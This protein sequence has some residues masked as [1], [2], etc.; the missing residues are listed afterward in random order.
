M[1]PRAAKHLLIG[2]T[3]AYS[4]KSATILGLAQPLLKQGVNLAY[5]KPLSQIVP[6]PSDGVDPD[7]Q[8]MAQTLGLSPK[9]LHP[10]LLWLNSERIHD[11][12]QGTD[13]TLYGQQLAHSCEQFAGDLLLLEGP[14]S[15]DEGHLFGLSLQQVADIVDAQVVLV[16][17]YH[18]LSVVDTLLC[19]KQRLGDRLLGVVINDVPAD[20]RQWCEQPL[21]D[22]LEAQG[23]RVLGLL[24]RS[25]LLRSVSVAELVRQ[26]NAEVLCCGDR[27]TLM[28]E[29]LA[30]GAMNVNSALKYFRKAQHMAVITGGDRTDIQ[31]AALESSTHCLILT[32][33]FSPNS[34]VLNRAED[35][36][37][38]VLLVDLD[39]L[40]TVEIVDQAFGQA[41]LHE[42]VKVEHVQQM[43]A[44]YFDLDRLLV[45]L[46]LDIGVAV[47]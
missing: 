12:I 44:Q 24:P 37:V 29:Q 21:R 8:L 45:A 38:P 40:T 5:G 35:L 15:L 16:A 34:I 28:V 31:L 13:R 1:V 10:T 41:Y 9:D 22:L 27:L 30:I 7:V 23:I 47:R 4:G 42:P 43:M 46:G 19:A 26:L 14:A 36:E 6:E 18:A 32:G 33:H 25:T 39:T 11:R 20:Q 3:E 2:S 17:R